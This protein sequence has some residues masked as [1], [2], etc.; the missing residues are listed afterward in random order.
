MRAKVCIPNC[1]PFESSPRVTMTAPMYWTACTIA[2]PGRIPLRELSPNQRATLLPLLRALDPAL[3]AWKTR[4]LL[5]DIARAALAGMERGDTPAFLAL[6]QAL[7]GLGV[8]LCDEELDFGTLTHM[9]GDHVLHLAIAHGA[10]DIV[11]ALLR[12]GVDVNRPSGMDGLRPLHVA[13]LSDSPDPIHALL[14]HGADPDAP[15]ALG[16]SARALAETIA[17]K[18]NLKHG[19]AILN[20]EE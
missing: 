18:R 4:P 5:P 13:V 12:R 14:E 9:C 8:D 3:P 1:V 2:T 11:Q 7:L 15:D 6:D 16:R 20:G 17:W 19:H 10:R